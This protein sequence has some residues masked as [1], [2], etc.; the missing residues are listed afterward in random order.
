MCS[1]YY[2]HP[3]GIAK[4]CIT[5]CTTGSAG[6]RGKDGI[7]GVPG[8]A[9]SSGAD[10]GPG[11]AGPTGSEGQKGDAGESGS[12]GSRGPRVKCVIPTWNLYYT[13]LSC[14]REMLAPVDLEVQLEPL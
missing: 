7:P 14:S 5:L 1:L 6:P 12:D 3:S 13:L 11:E 8:R 9:G 2:P 4:N 10:G